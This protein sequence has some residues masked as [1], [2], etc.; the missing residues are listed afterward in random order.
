[1]RLPTA[2]KKVI[3]YIYHAQSQLIIQ[4]ILAC[5]SCIPRVEPETG[6]DRQ[7][8]QHINVG[9]PMELGCWRKYERIRIS[10]NV[11]SL[12]HISGVVV[13]FIIS[14]SSL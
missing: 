12:F 7:S 9:N 11:A 14:S 5:N 13:I 2:D 3:F 10:A 1:L 6:F 8:I 4:A